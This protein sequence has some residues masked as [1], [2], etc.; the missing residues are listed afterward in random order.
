[1]LWAVANILTVFAG[2]TLGFR[3]FST[4]G[5]SSGGPVLGLA[6]VNELRGAARVDEGAGGAVAIVSGACPP[7][8][9]ATTEQSATNLPTPRW[10][11][12]RAPSAMGHDAPYRKAVAA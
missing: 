1:M 10:A 6:A 11:L 7:L 5:R 12:G 3:S 2:G 4:L 8:A 9:Y